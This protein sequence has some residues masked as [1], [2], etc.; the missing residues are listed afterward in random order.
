M[1]TYYGNSCL[2]FTRTVQSSG[3]VPNKDLLIHTYLVTGSV[4]LLCFQVGFALDG[5]MTGR[6]KT[7]NKSILSP[8]TITIH[9]KK[10][11]HEN[12]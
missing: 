1:I 8:K 6:T 9:S 5:R 3:Q 12:M 4:F 10:L 11:Y 2:N 7:N